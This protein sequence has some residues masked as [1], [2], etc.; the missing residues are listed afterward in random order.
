VA[1]LNVFFVNEVAKLDAAAG[2]GRDVVHEVIFGGCVE[3][4]FAVIGAIFPEDHI[5]QVGAGRVE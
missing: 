3:P 5:D 1:E 4:F 2:G